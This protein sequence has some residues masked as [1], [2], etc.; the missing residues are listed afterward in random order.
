MADS[1]KTKGKPRVLIFDNDIALARRVYRKFLSE[2]F[3]ASMIVYDKESLIDISALQLDENVVDY[4]VIGSVGGRW[5]DLA[6]QAEAYNTTPIIFSD[7]EY[8]VED[9]KEMGFHAFEKPEGLEKIIELIKSGA[10]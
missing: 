1:G 2:G 7:N 4:A 9:A 8:V 5:K 6:P 10:E 3:D